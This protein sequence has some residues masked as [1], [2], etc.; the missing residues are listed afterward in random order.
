LPP[1]S[2]VQGLHNLAGQALLFL[3]RKLVPR[4]GESSLP[5]FV[6]GL[7]RTTLQES[8][9]IS[10]SCITTWWPAVA[11]PTAKADEL[12]YVSDQGLDMTPPPIRILGATTTRQVSLPRPRTWPPTW[13]RTAT[14]W[15]CSGACTR[16]TRPT[17][18]STGLS[19]SASSQKAAT[20]AAHRHRRPRPDLGAHSV[21]HRR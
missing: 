18:Q 10:T 19:F 12:P 1:A 7:C 17:R 21:S 15:R 13:P 8:M 3:W 6:D 5:Q 20:R 11:A 9:D 2:C 14:R 16:C 4:F